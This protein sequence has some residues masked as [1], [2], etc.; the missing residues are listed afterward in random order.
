MAKELGSFPIWD[1][2]K[3]KENPFIN[4]IKNESVEIQNESGI[5]VVDGYDLYHDMAE[6]GRRNIANLTNSPAGT[7][8]LLTQ[9]SQGIE[10]VF[11]LKTK[12]RKKICPSDEGVRVDFV[13]ASG[14]KWMEFDVFHPK[15][16]V[17]EQKTTTTP[18]PTNPWHKCC[19]KD[20]DWQQRV[21]LQATA[22]K[23][24][25]HAIS[26]TIN[27][28]K[29]ISQ[30]AVR[31][32]YE[33]AWKMGCKGLTIYREGCRDGVILSQEEQ[34]RPRDLPCDVHHT[35]VD[36]KPYFVLVGLWEDGMPYEVFAGR[37]GF[38]PKSIQRGK[39]VRKRKS[40]YKAEF[41][42]S[43]LEL[44]PIT[45]STTEMEGAITRLTSTALRHGANMHLVVK[46]LEKVGEEGS[47]N[48]FARGVAR[49]LK[50]Y[51]KD[52]AKEFGE[53]CPECKTEGLVR[54]GGCPTCVS[55]GYAKCV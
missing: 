34:T 36:G 1:W 5:F 54:Q 32:I 46:Q 10:P 7:V 9:T 48:C 52:G 4:R 50:K 53:I 26:S 2:E 24:I 40:Y 51:I 55:C 21:K 43:D 11:E 37:N 17:F 13:D 49:C 22:Q 45:A 14:D 25:D 38:I 30:K 29:D 47:I 20:L 42:D 16:I 19:A 8:S 31:E 39:I 44:S 33:S 15:L 18:L 28:P 6:H 41:D 27:L 3:E 12:R 23:H 35:Q